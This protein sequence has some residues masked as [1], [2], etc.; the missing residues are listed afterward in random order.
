MG[1]IYVNISS[2]SKD[3]GNYAR[4]ER[5]YIN[6]GRANHPVKRHGRHR[7]VDHESL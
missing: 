3:E 7:R 2:L 1:G 6:P 5:P 4:S